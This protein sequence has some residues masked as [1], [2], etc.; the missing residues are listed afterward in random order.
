MAPALEILP[1][2]LGIALE[3]PQAVPGQG[4]RE[5][6][7]WGHSPDGAIH[8]SLLQSLLHNQHCNKPFA[9]AGE[10]VAVA[11]ACSPERKSLCSQL[12]Y[13]NDAA[14]FAQEE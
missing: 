10:G 4:G 2:V 14:L 3:N 12:L 11:S 13:V 7:I 8:C 9:G 1:G 5:E 6:D